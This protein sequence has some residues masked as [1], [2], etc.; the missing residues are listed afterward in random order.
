MTI[1]YD[2]SPEQFDLTS[3]ILRRQLGREVVEYLA[4]FQEGVTHEFERLN[5]SV[6]FQL[7]L[8][9]NLR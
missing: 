6:E 4:G 2:F 1:V 8:I 7:I 9:T 3:P 5:K